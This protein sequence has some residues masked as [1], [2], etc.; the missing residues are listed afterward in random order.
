MKQFYTASLATVAVASCVDCE[1]AVT[2]PTTDCWTRSPVFISEIVLSLPEN[3]LCCCVR[4]NFDILRPFSQHTTSEEIHE[5][6]P[7]INKP[8]TISSLWFSFD[9]QRIG[10]VMLFEKY[11]KNKRPNMLSYAFLAYSVT[12]VSM[13]PFCSS[14]LRRLLCTVLQCDPEPRTI[15]S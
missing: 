10:V 14:I 1:A 12:G 11:V 6:L 13:L 15:H 4:A 3:Y 5:C 2:A 7:R 8:S 9:T